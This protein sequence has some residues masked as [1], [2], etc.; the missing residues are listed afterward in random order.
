[1]NTSRQ[2][3]VV[4]E[5]NVKENCTALKVCTQRGGEKRTQGTREKT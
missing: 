2:G 5:K 1:M 3:G 4:R